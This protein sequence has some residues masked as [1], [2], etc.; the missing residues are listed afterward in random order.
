MLDL[1][2]YI[3]FL[4]LGVQA[5]S[6]VTASTSAQLNGQIQSLGGVGL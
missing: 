5:E 1:A 4:A 6:C 3:L 2:S